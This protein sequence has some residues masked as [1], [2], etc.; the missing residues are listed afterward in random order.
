MPISVDVYE[1]PNAPIPE[2]VSKP[3]PKIERSFLRAEGFAAIDGLQL[4]AIAD[5]TE[6]FVA[7]AVPN[8]RTHDQRADRANGA[9]QRPSH[10][11]R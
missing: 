4:L 5:F 3:P 2:F 7:Q 10:G 8:G 1:P 11:R 6:M 9:G